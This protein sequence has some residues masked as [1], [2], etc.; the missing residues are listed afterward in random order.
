M[1]DVVRVEVS[2]EFLRQLKRLKKSPRFRYMS[3]S[4]ITRHVKVVPIQEEKDS[5]Y[6][7]KKLLKN[8]DEELA[9]R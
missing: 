5:V 6:Y 9:V 8:M 7:V 2:K 1:S 3:L 4:E